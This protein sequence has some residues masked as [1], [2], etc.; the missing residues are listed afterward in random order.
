MQT[1]THPRIIDHAVATLAERRAGV[2]G[3]DQLSV[4]G[5]GSGAIKHRVAVGRLRRSPAT[6]ASS[7]W[8][9]PLAPR[10]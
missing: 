10:D 6:A 8:A 7:R 1:R 5:I 9:T 3:H 4:L 2:I